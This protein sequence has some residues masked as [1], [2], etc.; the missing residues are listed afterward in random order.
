MKG[1]L[2]TGSFTDFPEDLPVWGCKCKKKGTP[3]SLLWS[4][5]YTAPHF[6]S[7]QK[8]CVENRIWVTMLTVHRL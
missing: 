6:H 2:D 1:K 7:D 4:G 8:T 3:D 5:E